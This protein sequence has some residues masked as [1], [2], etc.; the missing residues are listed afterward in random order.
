MPAVLG[1]SLSY[2]P[3]KEVSPHGCFKGQQLHSAFYELKE[4][5]ELGKADCRHCFSLIHRII[6]SDYFFLV[7]FPLGCPD[8]RLWQM[9]E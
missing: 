5:V 6:S 3:G 9:Q 2:L 1:N 4:I 7:H 8:W